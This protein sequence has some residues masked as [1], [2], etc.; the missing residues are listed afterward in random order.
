MDAHAQKEIRDYA[1]LI[2]QQIVARWVPLTW[3]AFGDFR[4]GAA[5][6]SRLEQAVLAAVGAGDLEAARAVAREA[7]WLKPAGGGGLVRNR[8]RLECEQKLQALS[9]SVPW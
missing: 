4:L 6:W 7:G 1:T 8:E 5:S 9:L 3:E 2:G